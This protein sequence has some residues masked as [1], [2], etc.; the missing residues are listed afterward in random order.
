MKALN[1]LV[2]YELIKE[3]IYIGLI[4][5]NDVHHRRISRF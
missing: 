4:F 1:L 5:F 3:E 2:R